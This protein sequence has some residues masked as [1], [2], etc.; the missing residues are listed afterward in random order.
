MN[1]YAMVSLK[2]DSFGKLLEY[3]E[4]NCDSFY[5]VN[6][7]IYFD[8]H[9]SEKSLSNTEQ[10][11]IDYCVG[12]KWVKKWPGTK[13]S[14]KVLMSTYVMSD[15]C[16]KYFKKLGSFFAIEDE[17]DISFFHN[18]ECLCFSISHENMLFVCKS[19]LKYI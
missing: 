15:F 10:I 16:M 7:Y 2:E 4:E 3:L 17:I 9:F 1:V 19:I 18:D 14:H 6:Q 5:L 8:K 13:T 11:L 12:R